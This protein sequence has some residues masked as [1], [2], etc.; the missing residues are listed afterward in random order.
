MAALMGK[1]RTLL[2]FLP[3]ILFFS[4]GMLMHSAATDTY[5][6]KVQEWLDTA[7]TAMEETYDVES[8]DFTH[9]DEP[10]LTMEALIEDG[11]GADVSVKTTDNPDELYAY[12]ALFNEDTKALELVSIN[13]G[14]EVP[15]PASL[16]STDSGE[17]SEEAV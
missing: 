17:E 7:E 11:Q 12:K 6:E 14:K 1:E 4:S 15:S 5:E 16:L 9:A 13:D 8:V 3:V 10:S 2:S